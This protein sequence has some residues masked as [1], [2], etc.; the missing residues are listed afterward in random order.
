MYSDENEDGQPSMPTPEFTIQMVKLLG[1][2]VD[3]IKSAVIEGVKASILK[4]IENDVRESVAKSINKTVD[5]TVS[6]WVKGF[7]EKPY[8]PVTSW[9][10][11][12]GKPTTIRD[13]IEEK[14]KDFM[15]EKVDSSGKANDYRS[16]TPRYLWAARQ[17]A[18]EAMDKSLRPELDKMI[19]EMKEKVRAGIAGV[20]TDLVARKFQ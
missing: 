13:V 7:L 1:I 17:V 6:E 16:E 14:S 9:G 18:Q 8:Q 2:N 5:A 10:E 19:A 11:P 12:K 20:V 4:S 3:D 15:L